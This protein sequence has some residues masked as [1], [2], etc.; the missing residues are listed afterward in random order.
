MNLT[1]HICLF[2][3]RQEKEVENLGFRGEDLLST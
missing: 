3:P 1:I 2:G